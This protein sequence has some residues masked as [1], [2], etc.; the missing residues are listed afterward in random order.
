MRTKLARLRNFEGKKNTAAKPKIF[1]TN[2]AIF[3]IVCV[4]FPILKCKW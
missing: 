4:S 1:Y 2:V 3:L